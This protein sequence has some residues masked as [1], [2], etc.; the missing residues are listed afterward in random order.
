MSRELITP[1]AWSRPVS[2]KLTRWDGL[3]AYLQFQ[4]QALDAAKTGLR[5]SYKLPDLANAAY[6]IFSRIRTEPSTKGSSIVVG[7]VGINERGNGR[8]ASHAW[9]SN[10]QRLQIGSCASPC[11][12]LHTVINQLKVERGFL[13]INGPSMLSHVPLWCDCLCVFCPPRHNTHRIRVATLADVLCRRTWLSHRVE[14]SKWRVQSDRSACWH[15]LQPIYS[16]P[17]VIQ[18]CNTSGGIEARNT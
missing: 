9:N 12:H 17:D 10:G 2:P 3:L 4:A 6:G 15:L 1:V 5:N 18:M 7:W 11:E 13:E 16:M 14:S 8:E